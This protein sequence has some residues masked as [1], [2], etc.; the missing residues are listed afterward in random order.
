MLIAFSA[1]TTLFAA[2]YGAVT[3][4]SEMTVAAVTTVIKIYEI[5]SRIKST[6]FS[7]LF[8]MVEGSLQMYLAISQKGML[9]SKDFSIK[10]LLSNVRCFWFPG[11]NLHINKLLSLRIGKPILL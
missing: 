6:V 2:R 8:G 11:I 10:T 5:I 3:D 7:N 4:I 9:L 1:G